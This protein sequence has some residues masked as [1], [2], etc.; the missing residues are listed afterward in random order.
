[1]MAD[2][3]GLVCHGLELRNLAA[4]MFAHKRAADYIAPFGTVPGQSK[5]ALTMLPLGN[6]Q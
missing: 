6:T 5:V 4:A 1:M 2:E 3:G